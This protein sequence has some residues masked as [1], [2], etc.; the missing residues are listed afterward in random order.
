MSIRAE[1]SKI[2]ICRISWMR[3]YRGL[4]ND[5]ITVPAGRF[6][7]QNGWGGECWNFK[8][9]RGR[10][11]GYV[12]VNT[13]ADPAPVVRRLNSGAVAESVDDVTVVWVAHGG[14]IDKTYVVGWF[15]HSTVFG[16]F[17]DRPDAKR[18]LDEARV[19][20][21]VDR[22]EL[23]YFVTCKKEDARLLSE[24]ERRFRV[25]VG[26]GWMANMSLLFYP[27][28]G[29][30]HEGF[31]GRLLDYIDAH[32]HNA[33]TTEL[34]DSAL[35]DLRDGRSTIEGEQIL[36]T[37]VARERNAGL[38]RRAKKSFTKAHGRLFCEACG[39]DFKAKYGSLGKDFIEAHHV[40]P[41]TEGPRRTRLDDL[42]MLCANCH[43]MV[44]R[45]MNQKRRSLTR[46]E[47]A[48]IATRGRDS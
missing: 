38:V 30:E 7:R 24:S 5:A 2:L 18:I 32:R 6:P 20:I 15:E 34:P 40:T 22:E 42:M 1:R 10:M 44:H 19:D 29:A 25:P 43:R 26:K 39:F 17:L 13:R 45:Q 31:K 33:T 23:R 37:H 28:G 21:E 36:V 35:A 8:P 11:Y 48:N 47:S 12:R 9:W 46:D 3:E 14:A 4:T 27:D 16:E 41:L